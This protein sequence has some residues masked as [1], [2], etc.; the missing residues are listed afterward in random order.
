MVS[1]FFILSFFALQWLAPYL[2]YT[3]LIEEDYDFLPA[4]LGSFASLIV[5]YPV[6][7]AIPIA[8]KWIMIGRYRPGAYPLWGTLLLPVVVCD[9]HRSRCPRRLPEGHP[10]AEHLSPADGGQGRPQRASRDSDAF[11]IYDLLSIG[12]DSSINADSNLLGYT[13]EDGQLE[14]RQHHDRQAL[15]RRRPGC[16]REDTVMEDDSALEDL[17]LLP[18]GAVIP[19]GETW[20]GSP[21]MP[22]VGR[23]SRLPSGR[24]ALEPSHA[25]DTPG[26]A[27]E[28]PAPLSSP[29]RP[30]TARRFAFG[31]LHGIGLLIFPVLVVAALFPGIVCDEP[32]ELPR[33]VLLVSACWRPWSGVVHRASGRWKSPS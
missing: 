20:L 3:V 15:L 26:A 17:S 33:P 19:R 2:T 28:T 22:V 31:V 4:V 18:R 23:A 21:A 14:D 9:D 13:V 25:G 27:G 16:L 24:L 10:A 29:T 12:E 32:A 7:L 8:V 30:T 6:M 5:L 1:L 11:A